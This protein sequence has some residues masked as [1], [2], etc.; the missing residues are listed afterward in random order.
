MTASARR[1]YALTSV[2]VLGCSLCP[3]ERA[4]VSECKEG[5][6]QSA[7]FFG[8]SHG[9]EIECPEGQHGRKKA[10][11][12]PPRTLGAGDRRRPLVYDHPLAGPSHWARRYNDGCVLAHGTRSR[13]LD[14]LSR[15]VACNMGVADG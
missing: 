10:R 6:C 15:T 7:G 4:W 11:I 1:S 3:K 14:D 12:G 13:L 9:R 2:Q 8:A 5:S